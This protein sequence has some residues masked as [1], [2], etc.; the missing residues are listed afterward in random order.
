M[1]LAPGLWADP[2]ICM[3]ASGPG[4][5]QRLEY[6]TTTHYNTAAAAYNED[7]RLCN[8]PYGVRVNFQVGLCGDSRGNTAQPTS[9]ATQRQ[10]LCGPAGCRVL[11]GMMECVRT[12]NAV[13]FYA[14]HSRQV[15]VQRTQ[16]HHCAPPLVAPDLNRTKTLTHFSSYAVSC[17]A[18]RTLRHT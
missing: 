16:E 7:F 2:F 3:T 11:S 10:F 5:N 8:V 6:K 9:R 12:R 14:L 13:L 4:V 1:D 17:R 18:C 15:D